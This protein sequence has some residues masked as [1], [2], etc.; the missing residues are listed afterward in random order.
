MTSNS[1]TYRAVPFVACV[2]YPGRFGLTITLV[3]GPTRDMLDRAGR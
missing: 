3:S 1:S 2:T